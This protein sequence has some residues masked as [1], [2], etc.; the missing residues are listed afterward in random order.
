VKALSVSRIRVKGVLLAVVCAAALVG[1]GLSTAAPPKKPRLAAPVNCGKLIPASLA[2][3][4][5]GLGITSVTATTKTVKG[6]WTSTCRYHTATDAGSSLAIT[7]VIYPM[8]AAKRTVFFKGLESAA[9]HAASAALAPQCQPGYT[10]PEG[11]PP[12]KPSDC[13]VLH[14]FGPSSYEFGSAGLVVA[15]EKYLVDDVSIHGDDAQEAL[16][17]K[18]IAK[19]H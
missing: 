15:S 9:A 12:V 17:R 1:A 4:L 19:L 18:V 11:T 8:T 2:A 6:V 5:T 3:S 7:L 16:M 10:V 13:I 14:P